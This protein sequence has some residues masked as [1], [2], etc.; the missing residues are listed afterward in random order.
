MGKPQ[1]WQCKCHVWVNV[2]VGWTWRVR[3]CYG[4]LIKVFKH[5]KMFHSKGRPHVLAG[6]SY[7]IPVTSV[8]LTQGLCRPVS[9]VSKGLRC[10]EPI[11]ALGTVLNF[12]SCQ[13]LS[14]LDIS[15][16][17]LQTCFGNSAISFL[18]PRR[19]HLTKTLWGYKSASLWHLCFVPCP[20]ILYKTLGECGFRHPRN[21][22]W[23]IGIV[24]TQKGGYCCRDGGLNVTV[25]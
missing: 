15:L 12:L 8:L 14:S 9:V 21:K 13:G 17:G 23:M 10:P 6:S 16:L 1:R 24:L 7:L 22:R 11:C 3:E 19:R 2:E 4:E 25:L 5:I 20:G 18:P